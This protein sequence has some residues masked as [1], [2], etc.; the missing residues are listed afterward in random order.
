[1]AGF[2]LMFPLIFASSAFVRSRHAE[3]TPGHRRDQPS[4]R[5]VMVEALRALLL[6]GLTTVPVLQA[7]AWT[8]SISTVFATLP[9]AAIPNLVTSPRPAHQ[10]TLWRRGA[11]CEGRRANDADIITAIVD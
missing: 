7:L 10:R 6:S 8:I 5:H 4:H 11:G 3:R 1:V 2:L 9:S